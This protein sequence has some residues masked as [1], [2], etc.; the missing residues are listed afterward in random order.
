[1]RSGYGSLF[2]TNGEYFKG[3]FKND[4]PSGKGTFY[5]LGNKM[6]HGIWEYGLFIS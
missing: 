3:E 6:I 1:M 2:L 5:G 4:L